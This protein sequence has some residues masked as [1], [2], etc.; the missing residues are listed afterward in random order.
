MSF[1]RTD[2]DQP[3]A[4]DQGLADRR[5]AAE[6][7]EHQPRH[8]GEIAARELD[9]EIDEIVD[10]EAAREGDRPVRFVPDPRQVRV[11]LV[12]DLTD[13]LFDKVFDGDDPERLTVLAD[14]HRHLG[15]VGLELPQ[16][17][18]ARGRRGE[19][20]ASPASAR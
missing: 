7:V 4:D 20:P 12:V 18:R 13:Q 10:G 3:A 14:H 9:V 5:E 15:A 2:L 19:T 16:R 6:L 1:D 8:R 17:G 11:G